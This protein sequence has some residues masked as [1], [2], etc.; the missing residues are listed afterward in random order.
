MIRANVVSS[1]PMPKSFRVT[2]DIDHKDVP[3]F[4]SYT[5]AE[6][7]IGV[8]MIDLRPKAASIPPAARNAV[9]DTALQPTPMEAAIAKATGVDPAE[10]RA[11]AVD[12]R[13]KDDVQQPGVRPATG[14]V[15]GAGG[16]DKNSTEIRAEP[17]GPKQD[18]ENQRVIAATKAHIDGVR[19]G[20]P[21]QTEPAPSQAGTD[22]EMPPWMVRADAA[23][24]PAAKPAAAPRKTSPF[25]R[26]E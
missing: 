5:N 7:D 4:Q 17:S 21:V 19:N 11:W 2:V 25:A 1:R 24:P 8:V 26:G 10:T 15:V 3:L 18:V 22:P 20:A 14:A 9:D 6:F 16:A 12:G 23:Q 13:L